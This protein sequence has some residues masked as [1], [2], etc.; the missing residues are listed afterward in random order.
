MPHLLHRVSRLDSAHIADA[1]NSG[2]KLEPVRCKISSAYGIG[3]GP[4]IGCLF[5]SCHWLIQRLL[6]K[7]LRVSKMRASIALGMNNNPYQLLTNTTSS[8]HRTMKLMTNSMRWTP[9]GHNSVETPASF[10]PKDRRLLCFIF[11]PPRRGSCFRIPDRLTLQA[12][13]DVTLL[14]TH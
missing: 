9:L 4:Q 7:G 14:P 5:R 10:E 8:R 6:G 13:G 11:S 12:L 2:T 3:H 1:R